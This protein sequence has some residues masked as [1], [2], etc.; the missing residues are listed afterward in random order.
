MFHRCAFHHLA[1]TLARKCS[2]FRPHRCQLTA[3]LGTRCLDRVYVASVWACQLSSRCRRRTPRDPRIVY[4]VSSEGLAQ[5]VPWTRR[6]MNP[7]SSCAGSR[8]A[9]AHERCGIVP[10]GSS[11]PQ[12]RPS[13]TAAA[14][15]SQLWHGLVF[16]LEGVGD[17]MHQACKST[18]AGPRLAYSSACIAWAVAAWLVLT[19]T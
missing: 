10:P 18:I 5:K 3:V 6:P 19:C 11:W 8:N 16:N 15:S 4:E 9:P 14:A 7:W 17:L 13:P 2:G 1:A 12:W